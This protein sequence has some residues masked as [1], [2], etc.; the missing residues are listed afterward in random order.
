[1][2]ARHRDQAPP[3]I[4]GADPMGKPAGNLQDSESRLGADAIGIGNGRTP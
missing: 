2:P 1:M 3:E 4:W